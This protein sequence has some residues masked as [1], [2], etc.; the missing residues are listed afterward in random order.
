[1]S[2]KKLSDGWQVDIQPGGRG[3]KRHRRKFG[4]LSE[5]KRFVNHHEGLAVSQ[6]DWNPLRD[7]R[8]LSELVTEWFDNHGKTLKDG[9]RRR[10]ALESIAMSVG[11]PVAQSFQADEYVR[12]RSMRLS[13]GITAK[14]CN[15]ELTY[16]KALYNEL[17]NIGI[18]KF[19]NPLASI[20]PLRVEQTELSYLDTEQIAELLQT[21]QHENALLISKISLATG[22]R[23]G[24]AENLHR[25]QVKNGQIQFVSTKNGKTRNIPISPTLESEILSKRQGKLF[26]S[27]LSAFRR[28]LKKTS[29][30]LPKGQAAHVLRHTFASHFMINGGNI[31]TLQKILDHSDLKTTLRYAHLAPDH[32]SEVLELNPLKMTTD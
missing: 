22:C 1:M 31:L 19:G 27:S 11:N 18:I 12:Y 4:T 7:S 29:I 9:V 16:I 6:Q 20:K 21:I 32:L 5:A 25:R 28:A 14:T 15:N 17:Q 10:T 8:R 30:E 3:C 26:G 24:E 2:I 23:W 13:G